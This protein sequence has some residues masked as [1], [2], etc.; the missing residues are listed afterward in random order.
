MATLL[1]YLKK[2]FIGSRVQQAMGG[3]SRKQTGQHKD[4]NDED[5][6]P[7]LAAR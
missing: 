6:S 5:H 3:S 4:L 1:K 7:A 2:V